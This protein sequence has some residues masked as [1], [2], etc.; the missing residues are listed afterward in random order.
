MRQVV[1]F[2]PDMLFYTPSR[3]DLIIIDNVVSLL[4]G[5]VNSSSDMY[6]HWRYI[7]SMSLLLLSPLGTHKKKTVHK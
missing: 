1:L 5:H 7:Y 3:R 2:E 4:K 6:H